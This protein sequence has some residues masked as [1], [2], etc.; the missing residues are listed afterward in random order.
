MWHNRRDM[1]MP[2]VEDRPP[3]VIELAISL[4]REEFESFETP[5]AE[6]FQG[7]EVSDARAFAKHVRA[8]VET[9]NRAARVEVPSLLV[10]QDSFSALLAWLTDRERS[11]RVV[12]DRWAD[13]LGATRE[14]AQSME[15][16]LRASQFAHEQ[17]V[18]VQAT[19]QLA[20]EELL[21]AESGA[22]K[23]RL[24]VRSVMSHLDLSYD[25]VG[26]M[27]NVSG[28]TVRR[29]SQGSHAVPSGRVGQLA[30]AQA[31]LDRLL[32]IFRP[33]AFPGVIR[34]RTELFDGETAL[35]WILRGRI[36]EVAD[37]YEST[38]SYQA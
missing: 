34:R 14:V 5:I 15:P 23:A 38:L 20:M 36:D 35:D 6:D 28:E 22:E 4:A 1:A 13:L 33:E 8:V 17:L 11:F 32:G 21:R 2:R 26:R 10:V 9:L 12:V 37:R 31:A 3:E 24:A 29:W 25:E 27:F 16:L 18:E 7:F 30:A 19:F